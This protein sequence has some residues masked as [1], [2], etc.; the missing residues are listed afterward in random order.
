MPQM[1]PSSWLFITLFVFMLFLSFSCISY[2]TCPNMPSMSGN[3]HS[4]PSLKMNLSELL[5]GN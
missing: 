1:A 4:V 3:L 2:F 5:K